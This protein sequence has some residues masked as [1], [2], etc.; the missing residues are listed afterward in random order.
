MITPEWVNRIYDNYLEALGALQKTYLEWE[1][2]K[3]GYEIAVYLATIEGRIVGK[4]EAERDAC[5]YN[6]CESEY[7]VEVATR[8]AYTLAKHEFA[9]AQVEVDRIGV[10][11]ALPV[12]E[13]VS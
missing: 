11:M 3:E 13:K 2:A 5:A 7:R 4:N 1:D 10:L 8:R 9:L 12:V 6:Q